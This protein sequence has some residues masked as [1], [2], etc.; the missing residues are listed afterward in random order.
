MFITEINDMDLKQIAESGQCFRLMQT[1]EN[2]F[3]VTVSDFYTEISQK[4]NQFTFSCSEEEFNTVWE[5]YF[6]LKED[7]GKV[8]GL[9][10]P[11]DSYL[12]KAVLFG[13]GIRILRQDLWEMIITFLISQNNNIPRIRRSIDLLCSELGSLCQAAWG[14]P[15]TTFPGPEA[16]M[17]AGLS[18]LGRLGLGYRDK[19]ILETAKHVTDGSFDLKALKASEYE[20]AHLMLMEQYGIGKKVADCVCLFGL[21]HIDA[22][23]M[24]T[25][26][27]KIVEVHYSGSF[28]YERYKGYLGV[29]Q[30]YLFFYD[31]KAQK[32]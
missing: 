9:A 26:M 27:K 14:Q 11:A 6:D 20:K 18:G 2:T 10:D 19:Y 16:I 21:H 29:I 4:G 25:H 7:Y 32:L 12:S 30:Q 13:S 23:P 31:L 24:D 5:N 15:Y 28:P 3:A 17:D 8:K 1:G 22:F